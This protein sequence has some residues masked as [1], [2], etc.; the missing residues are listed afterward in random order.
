MPGVL[1]MGES[2]MIV[3]S[4]SVTVQRGAQLPPVAEVLIPWKNTR[5]PGTALNV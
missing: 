2:K 3:P 4:A 1:Q 5:A